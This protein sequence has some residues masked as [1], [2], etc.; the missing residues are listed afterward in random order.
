M[1]TVPLETA[2]LIAE[3]ACDLAEK[4]AHWKGQKMD[5]ANL[6]EAL[7]PKI[8]VK[9]IARTRG[10][11]HEDA[12]QLAHEI[13][14]TVQAAILGAQAIADQSGA[15]RADVSTS[16]EISEKPAGAVP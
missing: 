10:L 7:A 9:L 11:T 4:A 13:I 8:A 5:E 16:A 3:L 15:A 14:A 12:G 2:K 6:R 1:K